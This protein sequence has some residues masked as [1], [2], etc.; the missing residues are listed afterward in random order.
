M[1]QRRDTSQRA[2]PTVREIVE[3]VVGCKWTLHVLARVRAG[4]TRPGQLVRT[5]DGLTTK[6]L[7]ERLTK[8]VRH[9][10][11]VKIVYPESPPRV[12]YRLTTLGERLNTVLDA[13]EALQDEL[14]AEA[15][16]AP[17]RA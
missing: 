10:V 13:I 7:N 11:L 1:T 6:V 9:G 17:T 3:D 12:E 16:G 2:G 4:V 14:E 8:L 5:A 15:P